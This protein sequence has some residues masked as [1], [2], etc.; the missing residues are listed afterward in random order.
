MW[1]E[2]AA[3]VA[4]H[5]IRVYG[6][7]GTG[8][9]TWIGR[10]VRAELEKRAPEQVLITSLTKAAAETIVGREM[11]IPKENIG[12]LHSHCYRAI[13]GGTIAELK[14]LEFSRRFPAYA[15]TGEDRGSVD[16]IEAEQTTPAGPGD[17]LFEQYKLHRSRMDPRRTWTPSVQKFAAA[18]EKWKEETQ[19]R[20]F[21]DLIEL[22]YNEIAVAPGDPAVIMVDEAQDHDR[23]ELSLIRKWGRYAERVYIVG[24][25]DQA[26]YQ[27]RGSD[28]RA[29]MTPAVPEQNRMVL[30]QSWRVPAAVHKIAADW[31][32]QVR[33]REQIEYRP[34]QAPGAVRRLPATWKRPAG[35]LKD[36]EPYLSAGKEIM[37]L[38]SCAYM[39]NPLISELRT[40]GIPF[41]NPYRKK[42]G[43]WNPLRAAR[44]TSAAERLLA[45]LRPDPDA[46]PENSH[47]WNYADLRLWTDPIKADGVLRRGAKAELSLKTGETPLRLCE[48]QQLFEPEALERIMELSMPWYLEH[49]LKTRRHTIE[50]PAAIARSRG[51]IALRR[52][53]QVIVGTIHSVKGGEAD[54]VYL[55]PDLAPTAYAEWTAAGEARD[56]LIRLFYVAMTRTREDLILCAPSGSYR[57][58]GLA[59]RL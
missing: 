48:L 23:L 2:S 20:D 39:L 21:T 15:L 30:E 28:P 16:D 1:K 12:T 31:I 56:P 42:A 24:D 36:M 47:V 32:G 25:P 18:W 53:P 35:M 58:H 5:E 13:G 29:F 27:W 9:T 8:K 59:P 55:F 19:Y 22:A 44:G 10:Q 3:P 52:R 7:P 38:V 17:W 50:F 43:N 26:I 40:A 34:R 54:A 37:I 33:T 49:V 57:A 4:E 46:W 41:C 45:F 6:P 51:P 14:K 11:P